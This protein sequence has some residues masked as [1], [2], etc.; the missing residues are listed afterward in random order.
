MALDCLR[1]F[2]YYKVGH[3]KLACI[4]KTANKRLELQKLVVEAFERSRESIGHLAVLD[5][6]PVTKEELLIGGLDLKNSANGDDWSGV[7]IGTGYEAEELFG[8][9]AEIR[10]SAPSVPLFC[11]VA[12]EN[13]SIRV[14]RRLEK[15][16]VEV[17]RTDES[18]IRVVHFILKSVSKPSSQPRG[19]LV[20]VDGAKGGLGAS[21]IV[22]GIAH[23]AFAEGKSAVV[24][25]LSKEGALFHYLQTPKW[26]SSDYRT[27]LIDQL[28][29]TKAA[30]DRILVE[31]PNGI[32]LLLPPA[33]GADIRE[34]WLRSS[35]TFEITLGLVELLKERFDLVLIDLAR[36]EGLLPFSLATRADVRIV[37][38]SNEPASVHLLN[39]KLSELQALPI[40]SRTVVLL[41]LLVEHS[42]TATDV[43]D[44]L[45][46][47][48]SAKLIEIIS[49]PFDS[50]GAN[51]IGSGNSL[52]TEGSQRL[53]LILR[54][55]VEA[56]CV[57]SPVR[58]ELELV[59]SRD[60]NSWFE[61][62]GWIRRAKKN[63]QLRL[64]GPGPEEAVESI[65]FILTDELKDSFK[66]FS[67]FGKERSKTKSNLFEGYKSPI[68]SNIR[69][70]GG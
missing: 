32:K 27:F 44:F 67:N 33:G 16:S 12:P 31:A 23:A 60:T 61:R 45:M 36:A 52:Y 13:Y 57:G 5:F 30:L 4:D 35:Q 22:V 34:I 54:K 70:T 17:F 9:A 6:S 20:A 29:P 1:M 2:V 64:P 39:D 42:L 58:T 66:S 28:A 56:L 25:D 8:L 65:N 53:Q 49:L 63:D 19:K 24:I 38:S 40:T 51:W 50:L 11:F 41:N 68:A 59:K 3:M 26:Q 15:Y 47:H 43:E 7:I 46:M 69:A 55:L 10:S 18:F 62:L 37:V 14:L 21:S 48:E